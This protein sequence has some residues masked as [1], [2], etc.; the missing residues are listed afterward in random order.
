[1][2][3]NHCWGNQ[4]GL[5]LKNDG[6]SMDTWFRVLSF[7]VFIYAVIRKVLKDLI[8]L[9]NILCRSSSKQTRHFSLHSIWC[10][11]LHVSFYDVAWTF[12][13]TSQR[14]SLYSCEPTICSMTYKFAL[15]KYLLSV[16]AIQNCSHG[17]RRKTFLVS[18]PIHNICR[19]LLLVS[20]FVEI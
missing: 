20:Q 18:W 10:F 12:K 5:G 14:L 4:C 2:L 7:H 13:Q 6:P 1:M 19:C 8:G 16:R 17:S 15:T 9:S 3:R 11:I